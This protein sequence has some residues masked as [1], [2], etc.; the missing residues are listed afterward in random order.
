M[1]F[2]VD[3]IFGLVK[4]K[5]NLLFFKCWFWIII[6][7]FNFGLVRVFK[8]G[9]KL[10]LGVL[11]LFIVI[12]CV[13]VRGVVGLFKKWWL[14]WLINLWLLCRVIVLFNKVVKIFIKVVFFFRYE[15]KLVI[16]FGKF[17]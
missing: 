13:F 14:F 11:V 4:F 8:L 5:V 15:F 17:I 7:V 12:K 3:K 16:V 1:F 2:L 10:V 6:V 9:L